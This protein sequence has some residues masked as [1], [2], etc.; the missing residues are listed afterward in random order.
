MQTPYQIALTACTRKHLNI[1][2]A[3][4]SK[5]NNRRWQAPGGQ[6]GTSEFRRTVSMRLPQKIAVL[7]QVRGAMW[8]SPPTCSKRFCHK[9]QHIRSGYWQ[10][11]LA[12]HRRTARNERIPPDGFDT[13]AL[14]VIL[15]GRTPPPPSGGPP[16]TERSPLP[17]G[18]LPTPWGVTPFRGGLCTSLR[19]DV[20]IAPY[21]A[22][23][24]TA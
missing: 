20:G 5:G 15:H 24:V 10:P 7:G 12:S 3:N 4:T 2:T 9:A 21:R 1:N 22:Q 14:E 6:R 8:A 13:A 16:R 19:G 17:C 18:H 11:A 23:E